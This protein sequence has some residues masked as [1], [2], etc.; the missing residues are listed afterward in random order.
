MNENFKKTLETLVEKYDTVLVNNARVR[1]GA[2]KRSIHSEI[3]YNSD[4][5]TVFTTMMEYGIYPKV[6]KNLKT[7]IMMFDTMIT[8]ELAIAIGKDILIDIKQ[9]FEK[10]EK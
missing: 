9:E 4:D 7:P 3:V 8:G 5:T 2:L 6:W 1:T 10:I